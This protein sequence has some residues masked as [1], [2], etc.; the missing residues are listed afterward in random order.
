[1]D[2]ETQNIIK[3]LVE[4]LACLAEKQEAILQ[5]LALKLPDLSEDEKNKL[6]KSAKENGKNAET[7]RQS[8][9]TWK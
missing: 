7:W 5:L 9:K 1:M 8:L 3:P 4:N 6:L 2:T